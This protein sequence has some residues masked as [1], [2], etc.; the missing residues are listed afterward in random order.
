MKWNAHALQ[1]YSIQ[2]YSFN[3]MMIQYKFAYLAAVFQFNISH[4][5]NRKNLHILCLD[6][7]SNFEHRF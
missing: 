5:S 4:T 6:M 3:I 7:I 2:H 1:K